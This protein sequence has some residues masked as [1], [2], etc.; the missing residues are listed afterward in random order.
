MDFVVEHLK[1]HGIK[2]SV[3]RVAIMRYLME[4]CTH[5]TVDAIYCDLQAQM[6]TLS[7]T[8]V[9]NTL[10]LLEDRDAL[11]V[12]TIDS[13]NIHYDGD[14]RPHAHFLCKRCGRIYDLPHGETKKDVETWEMNGH[15]VQ[16]IHFY[17][18]GICKNCQKEETPK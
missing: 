13:R 3:Q 15:N 12:L 7:R 9:Y 1:K 16:E 11:S 6:P 17:Y 2:P 5:P 14:T 18:K 8:T 10:S 4:H